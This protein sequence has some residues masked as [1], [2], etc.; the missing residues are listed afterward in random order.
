MV[1][2]RKLEGRISL[3]TWFW[4]KNWA[5]AG[6]CPAAAAG[7]ACWNMANCWSCCCRDCCC[8]WS[9]EARAWISWGLKAPREPCIKSCWPTS[10][11]A[12]A[13]WELPVL[14]AWLPV[15]WL[16]TPELGE[17]ALPL[18]PLLL[19]RCETSVT[20]NNFY[21]FDIY[22]FFCDIHFLVLYLFLKMCNYCHTFLYFLDFNKYHWWGLWPELKRLIRST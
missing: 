16:L 4:R 8:C 7:F 13:A 18:V 12:R 14:P 19:F 22:L 10:W 11:A 5:C 20:W 3:R 21:I 2:V 6:S 1:R 9:V 15:S 17:D